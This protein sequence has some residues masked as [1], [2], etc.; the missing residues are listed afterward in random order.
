MFATQS[1]FNERFADTSTLNELLFSSDG[2]LTVSLAP[3]HNEGINA[4]L[5]FLLFVQQLPV[6][7]SD[8]VIHC[9]FLQPDPAN[10]LKTKIEHEQIN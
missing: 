7:F 10:H 5:E 9:C 8:F 4:E 3:I 6:V 1:A 2:K